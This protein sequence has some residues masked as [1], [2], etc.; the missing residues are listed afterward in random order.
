[1]SHDA[2]SI[3][4]NPTN[5]LAVY[6][7]K[8]PEHLPEFCPNPADDVAGFTAFVSVLGIYKMRRYTISGYSMSDGKYKETIEA[9]SEKMALEIAKENGLD[10]FMTRYTVTI[11]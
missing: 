4:A 10:T 7:A 5:M 8:H 3:Q 6:F 11:E 9:P 2:R 1:M